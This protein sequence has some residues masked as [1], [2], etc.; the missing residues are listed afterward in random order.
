MIRTPTV[1]VLGAGASEPYGFPTSEQLLEDIVD[2]SQQ[3][4]NNPIGRWLVQCGFS[5]PDI[6]HFGREL[7]YSKRP[8]VDRFLELRGDEFLKIGTTAIAVALIPKEHQGVLMRF[9][10]GEGYRRELDWYKYLWKSMD[11]PFEEFGENRLSIITFN[12]DR[13][14]EF[15]LFSSLKASYGKS[16]E[17]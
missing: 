9:R 17:E 12:Y 15:Y 3:I 5:E 4:R 8:S 10:K 13:S 7:Q 6:T 2:A 1:L 14:L 11:A 16:D